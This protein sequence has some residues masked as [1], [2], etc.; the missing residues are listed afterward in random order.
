MDQV[1]GHT[2][3]T[4]VR[5]IGRGRPGERHRLTVR[6]PDDVGR[7]RRSL[8]VGAG[9][10]D[11]HRHGVG[12]PTAGIDR[13]DREGL[14]RPGRQ[15]G[16]PEGQAVGI[17]R[18]RA[19]AVH[20]V[21]RDRQGRGRGLPR[22]TDPAVH[23]RRRQVGRAERRL[24]VPPEAAEVGAV[25]AVGVVAT[26]VHAVVRVDEDRIRADRG[27][28]Q[29]RPPRGHR[30][31][32]GVEPV[33]EA[34]P[35]AAVGERV[36]DRVVGVA[37]TSAEHHPVLGDLENLVVAAAGEP[38][39]RA[40]V[41]AGDPGGDKADALVVG[42]VQHLDDVLGSADVYPVVRVHDRDGVALTVRLVV[43]VCRQARDVGAG[44]FGH[45]RETGRVRLTVHRGEKARRMDTV[46]IL[47][48]RQLPDAS[49]IHRCEAEIDG[50]GQAVEAGHALAERRPVRAVHV[51][52]LTGDVHLVAVDDDVADHRS[53]ARGDVRWE[54]GVG[55]AGHRVD[56][57][58]TTAGDAVDLGELAADQQV[59]VGA[60]LD[61]IDGAVEHRPKRGDPGTGVAL[62]RREVRLRHHLAGG[63]VG[64]ALNAG[65]DARDVDGVADL[66]EVP[67]ERLGDGIGRALAHDPPL[68]DGGRLE[69]GQIDRRQ[70][71]RIARSGLG[72]R[73][74]GR[75]S[76]DLV[77]AD[78][79]ECQPAGDDTEHGEHGKRCTSERAGTYRRRRLIG[80]KGCAHWFSFGDAGRYSR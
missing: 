80:W 35:R 31:V 64:V 65:E 63:V 52:D 6:R 38:T 5:Q 1:S 50:A 32:R 33:S 16:E 72:T 43:H 56:L 77:G 62:E 26:D 7:H 57:D 29:L 79:A 74:L 73:R 70:D 59:A 28:A 55:F 39:R 36:V 40:E 49:G 61:R 67:D 18:E 34:V 23:A 19:A 75:R 47:V 10:G 48:D 27:L 41:V 45:A 58:E 4:G 66:R 60:F 69:R 46:A 21:I 24:A 78:V 9:N 25:R 22:K 68:F 13:T 15:V 42:G 20:L 11:R 53:V 51:G 2:D 14:H 54:T 71:A 37:V 17:S 76:W 30:V 8:G 3:P 12:D 44:G